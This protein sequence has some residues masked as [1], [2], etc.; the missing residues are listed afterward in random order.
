VDCGLTCESR[1]DSTIGLSSDYRLHYDLRLEVK[2]EL[3]R[4][5]GGFERC[6]AHSCRTGAAPMLTQIRNTRARI[7]AYF[8]IDGG[9]SIV[10]GPSRHE[11]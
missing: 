11:A 2:C 7:N 1:Y 4:S 3:F 8:L 10:P 6:D 9:C 5:L